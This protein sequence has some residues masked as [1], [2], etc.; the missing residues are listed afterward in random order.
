MIRFITARNPLTGRWVWF[1]KWGHGKTICRSNMNYSTRQ[2]A[3]NA[4][5]RFVWYISK[6]EVDRG[7]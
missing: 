3:R 2:H 4:L 5:R 7:A 1:A 6:G